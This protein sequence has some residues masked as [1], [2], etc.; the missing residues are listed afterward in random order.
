MVVK[1]HKNKKGQEKGRGLVEAAV[2]DPVARK[3]L[4]KNVVFFV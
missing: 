1:L 4:P 2:S 3:A